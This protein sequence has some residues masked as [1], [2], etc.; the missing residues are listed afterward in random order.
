MR[1]ASQFSP[2][3]LE[4]PQMSSGT[5]RLFDG[6]LVG[7]APP[8]ADAKRRPSLSVGVKSRLGET[9]ALVGMTSRPDPHVFV[10]VAT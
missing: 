10:E 7:V 3:R 8:A 5:V 2:L 9:S 6:S 4:R 1:K